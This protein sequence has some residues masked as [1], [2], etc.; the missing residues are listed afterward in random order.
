MFKRFPNLAIAALL[1]LVLGLGVFQGRRVDHLR[2]SEAFYRWILAAATNERLFQDREK[3]GDF[4]DQELF[5]EITQIVD[6]TLADVALDPNLPDASKVTKLGLL[7]GDR[8]NDQS[9]WDLARG[10]LLA[11]QRAQFLQFARERKLQFAKNIQYAQAQA[12]DVNVFNLFFGFRKIAANFLWLQVDRYWH[13]GLMYRMIP[14]MRTCVLLDPNFVDAYLLG[15]WH[16]AYNA[17]ASM[18]ETPQSLKTWSS[19]YKLCLGE[20]ETYYYIAIDFLRDG[21]Q[22]NTR[23]YRLYFDLGFSIYKNKLNDYPNAVRYLTEAV[24]QPHERWVRRQLYQCQELNGQYEEALAG[25]HD[26]VK[27]FP[28]FP[29]SERFIQRNVA[30]IHEANMNKAREAA[31]TLTDADAI[32][33]KLLEAD[34]EKQQAIDIW[35]QLVQQQDPYGDYRILLLQARD[36]AEKQRYME[37]AAILD[38]ARW[39]SPGN[40]DEASDLIIEYKQKGNLPLSVSEKKAVLRKEEGDTCKGMPEKSAVKPAPATGQ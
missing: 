7:V 34:T 8:A 9:I 3:E 25:W 31:K 38:K 13:Q 17:T 1:L 33:A 10:N 26:Y 32:K 14:L 21:I 27:R 30:Q 22:N 29:V 12:G 16:L 24:R 28:D 40:F 11:P 15:A 4:R 20:K 5:R 2:Q 35:K 37:A 36:L 23:E 19:K 39:E 18:P 6:P